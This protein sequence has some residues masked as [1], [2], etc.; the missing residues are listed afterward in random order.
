[1]FN[2]RVSSNSQSLVIIVFHTNVN[3]VLQGN[4]E[5]A[6]SSGNDLN[7]FVDEVEVFNL[8]DNVCDIHNLDVFP[9]NYRKLESLLQK[10]QEQ[11]SLLNT[12][13]LS[14]MTKFTSELTKVS[15]QFQSN[16]FTNSDEIIMKSRMTHFHNICQTVQLLC[17]VRGFKNILKYFT[18]EVSHLEM[19]LYMLGMQVINTLPHLFSYC[20]LIS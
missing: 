2:I 6:M 12:S 4:F 15:T 18:H 11:P 8:V 19:C 17:R 5:C 3:R 13:M 7:F 14:M 16:L 10:Y 1:M 9:T 20:N